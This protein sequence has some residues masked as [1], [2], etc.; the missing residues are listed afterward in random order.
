MPPVLFF[1]CIALGALLLATLFGLAWRRRGHPVLLVASVAWLAYA[2][3]EAAIQLHTPQAALRADLLLLWPLLVLI[4]LY[5][6][7]RARRPAR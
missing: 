4:S 7:W 1:L 5:A 6:L 2:L 3:Y